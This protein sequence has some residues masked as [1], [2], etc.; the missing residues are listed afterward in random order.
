MLLVA[1]AVAVLG[2]AIYLVREVGRVTAPTQAEARAERDDTPAESSE[3]AR[4]EKRDPSSSRVA[5]RAP[6]AVRAQERAAVTADEGKP[7]QV[8]PSIIAP[9]SLPKLDAM[10]NEANKAYDRHDFDEAKSIAN[11]VLAKS[12]GNVRM[13]RIL[14]SV[15][16]FDQDV[17]EAKKHYAQLPEKDRV[18]MR[19]RCGN[20]GIT[21]E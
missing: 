7:V 18:D 2:V 16:C 9:G 5:K 13:L 15:A 4:R 8:K 20:E 21:L 17:G 14:V 10:M 19:R 3:P 6:I 1:G 12:P 11:R